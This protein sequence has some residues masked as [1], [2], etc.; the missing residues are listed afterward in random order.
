MHIQQ[1]DGHYAGARQRRLHWQLWRP[2]QA[3]AVVVIAHGLAEH[4]GRYARLAQHL[5]QQGCAV[6]ALDHRGHGQSQGR[7]AL[8]EKFDHCVHD[9]DPL[10]TLAA[11]ENPGLKP[12]LLGHS[13]GGVIAVS[14]ALQ[15]QERLQGLMLSAPAL[16]VERAAWP[17]LL[18][19]RL[20]SALA[21]AMPV[22]AI[23]ASAVSRDPDEVRAYESDPLN[24]RG[25]LPART[26]VEL[27]DRLAWLPAA[28]PTLQLPLL[29]MH[30][31]ADRLALFA[32]GE[33]L[34]REAGSRDKTLLRYEGYY[35]ELFN[36]P[37]ADRE[38]VIADLSDWIRRHTN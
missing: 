26:L 10:V 35:H 20:L 30:G 31:T 14:Y 21:P 13:F 8:I 1:R 27:L 28:Y 19:A 2:P 18:V 24:Y 38:R 7:R 6:Y 36:E 34:Y 15:H 29:V 22:H 4:G 25:M 17:L 16:Q 12:L 5:A 37:A 23:D 33:R 9:L 3:T 32:G 11:D